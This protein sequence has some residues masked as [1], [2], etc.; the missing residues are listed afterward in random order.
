MK[1]ALF[2]IVV[3]IASL[4]LYVFHG[5]GGAPINQDTGGPVTNEESIDYYISVQATPTSAYVVSMDVTTNLPLPVEVM[6][7]ISAV[8]QAPTDTY[9]GTSRRFTLL[10]PEQNIVINGRSDHLPSGAYTAEVTFYPRW[11]AEHSPDRAQ[12]ISREVI[13][14]TEV[15]LSGS[16]ESREHAD[17]RNISQRWVMDH[18]SIGTPWNETQ[19][20]QRL[21]Q[22]ERSSSTLNLHDAYYFPDTDMTIIVSRVNNTVAIWRMGEATR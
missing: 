10:E 20:V 18:V 21:G 7:S 9:I 13:G 14:S 4:A 22:F 3:L 12:N 15:I 6:A 11:G 1:R 17:R 16:G 8:G 5:D 19:F 2:I